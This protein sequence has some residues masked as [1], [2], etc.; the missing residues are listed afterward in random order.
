MELQG[1][2]GPVELST[3]TIAALKVRFPA[4][5]VDSEL[6]RAHLWLLRNTSSRPVNIWRFLDH[7]FAKAPDVI[8][9]PAV[10]NAWWATDE[11]TINQGAAIG[12]QARPGETMAQY[13][14]RVADKM[15]AA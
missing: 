10:V 8:R 15:R 5:H 14:S 4:K 13:R 11:R 3:D 2:A 7:W 1:K 6:L 9:P 12:I